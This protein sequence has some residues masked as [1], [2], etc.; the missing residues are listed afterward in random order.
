METGRFVVKEVFSIRKIGILGGT[1]DPVHLGHLTAA[2]AVREAYDLEQVLFIPAG[3]P[4]HKLDQTKTAAWHRYWMTVLAT[5]D[6]P[7]FDVSPVE[8]Q[9]EGVSYTIDTLMYFREKMGSESEIYFIA[10]ADLVFEIAGWRRSDALFERCVFVIV[11]RPGFD[12]GRLRDNLSGVLTQAQLN[13]IAPLEIP[14][15]EVSSTEIRQKIKAGRTVRY[16]IP[17]A[18][19]AYIRKNGLYR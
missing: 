9:R 16:L 19:D 3:E 4:P 10:G 17:E 1:F 15:L 14:A 11:T 18:V 13:R 7:K 8:I 6:N 5:L 2:E 12:F